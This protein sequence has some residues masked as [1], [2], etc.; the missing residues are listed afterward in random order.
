MQQPLGKSLEALDPI[1]CLTTAQIPW[2]ESVS[3]LFIPLSPA[4]ANQVGGQSAATQTM[5]C[6][7]PT[8][9]EES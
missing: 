1:C 9:G 5:R 6:L 7:Q 3:F 2:A 8:P 4:K